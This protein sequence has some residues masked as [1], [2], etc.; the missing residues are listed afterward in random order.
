MMVGGGALASARAGG[1]GQMS[2]MPRSKE[3]LRILGRLLGVTLANRRLA[4]AAIVTL[5]VS[6]ALELAVPRLIQVAIDG[7]IESREVGI[8]VVLGVVIV[9][10]TAFKGVFTFLATYLA[11]VLSQKTTFHLRG[12]LFE[13]IQSLS[14][15]FHDKARTGELMS[16]TTS[17][18]DRVRFLAGM[19]LMNSIRITLMIVGVVSILMV[20]NWRLALLSL[21]GLPV[22][23]YVALAFSQR[24]RPLFVQVQQAWGAVNTV[25]QENLTGVKVVRAFAREEDEIAK[26]EPFNE[27]LT[28]SGIQVVRMFALRQPL[29]EAVAALGV[30]AVLWYGG[31]QVLDGNLTIGELVAFNTYLL[32]LRMPIQMLGFTVS[33]FARATASGDRIF[34]ILDRQSDVQ[35]KPDAVFNGQI[36]GGV[37][38]DNVEFAYEG[39]DVLRGISFNVSPGQILG[40]VGGTGSGKSTVIN[41]LPRFYDVTGGRIT[42][43]GI[44]IRDYRIA[45]LRAAIGIVSQETFLFGANLRENISYGRPDATDATI[46]QAAEAA[47]LGD[48]IRS[49][50]DG[51]DTAIGERGTTLSGGQKQRVAIARALL[52][53]PR[54]LILD[55]STSSVDTETERALQEALSELMKGRT[56]LIISQRVAS[57]VGADEIV[58]LDAG[59]IV[60]RG[61]HKALLESPG[62]YRDMYEMQVDAESL[63]VAEPSRADGS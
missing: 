53:D 25:L 59:S 31:I 57:V 22:L 19:G 51:L 11:E 48:F 46:L 43:D 27:D 6:M 35:E 33:I 24:I 2:R 37:H 17:D 15:S 47:Q 23:I 26:F 63:H 34:E 20:S 55:E 36:D 50:P 29:F 28:R 54:I 18:V 12:L 58:V 38:F 60:Q 9:G 16:R 4:I 14:F 1:T 8:A 32:L 49:L 62:L 39:E 5:V 42:M 30:A 45:P 52:L 7:T 56:T 44:D 21:A 41:L 13:R 10:I 40:I 3:D 61:R